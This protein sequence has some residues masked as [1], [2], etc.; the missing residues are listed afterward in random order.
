M[1]QSLEVQATYGRSFSGSLPAGTY[2][3]PSPVP[4]ALGNQFPSGPVQFPRPR[5]A[6]PAYPEFNT[7]GYT[8]PPPLNIPLQP[9]YGV[10]INSP[11]SA[12]PQPF[13]LA[14][15]AQYQRDRM[16]PLSAS[17]SQLGIQESSSQ[18]LALLVPPSRDYDVTAPAVFRPELIPFAPII[19]RPA[20]GQPPILTAS[21]PTIESLTAASASVANL[22]NPARK[23]AWSRQVMNLVDRTLNL[24]QA[25]NPASN[26]YVDGPRISDPKLLALTD[27]AIPQILALCQA[28]LVP[29][30]PYVAEAFYLRGSFAASGMFPQYVARDLRASFKDYET[31]ARNGYDAGW[32][33]IGRD[34][35]GVQDS[36]RATE[37]FERGVHLGEK[38]CLY[39]S[40]FDLHILGFSLRRWVCHRGWAWHTYKATWGS[41]ET[42]SLQYL[43]SSNPQTMRMQTRPKQPTCLA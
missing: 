4:P 19:P 11:I 40:S 21:L 34:Y 37:V 3:G 10:P 8:S 33:K 7:E 14:N 12:T 20:P 32:F 18:N 1:A 2:R 16:A 42:R 41:Q 28:A 22:G 27:Q 36:K 29:M 25:L 30:P 9:L 35:E 31:A 43:C 6:A 13:A 17:F 5:S 15:G 38:N 39:V 26:N 23:L 24:E